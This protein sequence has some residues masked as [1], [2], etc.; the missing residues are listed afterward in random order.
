MQT[1]ILPLDWNPTRAGDDVLR[2]LVTV[3][4]PQVKGAHDAEMALV[5]E[6]AYIVAEVNDQRAG[7]SHDWPEIYATQSIVHLETLA[8]E[9]IIPFAR[10]EQAFANAVLPVGQ[11]FVP[12]ILQKDTRTLRCYFASQQPGRREAQTW[13]LDFDLATRTFE[14]RI[15]PAKLQTTAGLVNM[16][17]RYFHA[18]AAAHGFTK[19]AHDH[20]LY[21]FDSFKRFDGRIY[22]AINN[23]PGQQNAL[24]VVND[25][26]DTF[27]IV[28][29]YNE[30]QALGLSESAVNRLPDGTWM[31]ICRQDGGNQNYTFTTS[32]DGQTWTPGA[33]RDCV[34]NGT[35]SKPTFDR[36][37]DWY[38][39][40][41]QE[42]TQIDGVHRSVFNLDVS[43]DG[44]RWERAY[45]FESDASFQYPTFREH[46]GAIYLTATQGDPGVGGKVR[47]CFG[48]LVDHLS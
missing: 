4:A 18:D 7:E 43:R 37:G 32:R 47:I 29:H 38:Y 14:D 46:R 20:G 13:Y 12:R 24:A 2:R 35:N 41:W 39:L 16:Q 9:A 1:P 44:E 31:A 34:A 45:R 40:G 6:H 19:P 10:S 30:P 36:F 3:T 25:A 11:C 5:G 28:G 21:L 22:V 27:E 15:F 33:H 17:P 8:V 23:F 48:K 42:A 26:L